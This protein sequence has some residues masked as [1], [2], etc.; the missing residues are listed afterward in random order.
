MI[1]K[2]YA[3]SRPHPPIGDIKNIFW[4]LLLLPRRL[5]LNETDR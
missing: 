2:V 4:L 1:T 5:G 3:A